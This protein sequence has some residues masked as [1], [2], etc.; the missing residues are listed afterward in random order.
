MNKGLT[1]KQLINQLLNGNMDDIIYIYITDGEDYSVRLT[2]DYTDDD[3]IST[4]EMIKK[5]E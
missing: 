5:G 3:T 4:I 2:I 1:R